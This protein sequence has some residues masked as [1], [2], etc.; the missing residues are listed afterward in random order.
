MPSRPTRSTVRAAP[1]RLGGR[2]DGVGESTS[3]SRPMPT[4]CCRDSST[5][6]KSW[7]SAAVRA[8]H[9]AGA[10][11]CR[12][13]PSTRMRPPVGRYRP[14][15][16]LSSVLLP[17][18][19]SPTSATDAPAGRCRSICAQRVVRRTPGYRNATCLEAYAVAGA[20]R[21]RAG[22]DGRVAPR[23]L[24]VERDEAAQTGGGA[25]HRAR[26]ARPRR[27]LRPELRRE[28][29]G[30]DD[31]TGGGPPG[32]RELV[33]PEHGGDVAEPEHQLPGGAQ[34][35][36]A[37]LRTRHRRAVLGE[38]G[39][40][41]LEQELGAPGEPH[42]LLGG[43]VGGE[44]AQVPD[45]ARDRRLLPRGPPAGPPRRAGRARPAPRQRP[46]SAS[47]HGET[48]PRTSAVSSTWTASAPSWSPN[49]TVDLI[50]M[51]SWRSRST[52]SANAGSSA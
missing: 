36:V 50:C 44:P 46:G 20:R 32:A 10:T 37:P 15:S 23:D 12:S 14:A 9:A 34:E 27:H 35:R 48:A 3:A 29:D 47:S 1:A 17:A 22:A 38:Q 51:T 39:A 26:G 52:R 18:P 25:V 28:R 45:A 7:N 19:F 11:S 6:A 8:R 24:L 2:G 13:T 40:L 43:R 33:H 49:C 41:P 4:L 5:R 42:L 21:D 31:V 30:E 16:S